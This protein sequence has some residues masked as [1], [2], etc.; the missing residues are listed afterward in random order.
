MALTCECGVEWFD[1]SIRVHLYFIPRGA[2]W[3]TYGRRG[4]AGST[5]PH[6]LLTPRSQD[7][8]TSDSTRG[9]GEHFLLATSRCPAPIYRCLEM[10]CGVEKIKDS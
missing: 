6:P 5:P 1:P 4:L 10:G 9:G 2:F 3:S 7:L 8:R